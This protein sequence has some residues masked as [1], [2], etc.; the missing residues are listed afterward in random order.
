IL[1]TIQVPTLVINRTG[2]PV[3]NVEAA[4]DM[5]ARIPGARFVEFPGNMHTPDG[6]V[7]EVVGEIREFI[8]GVRGTAPVTR[9]L[10]TIVFVDIVAST[11]LATKLGD[12]PFRDLLDRWYAIL[13]RELADYG[14]REINRAGD[15][16]L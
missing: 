4:R 11:E 7:E 14:G 6:I 16:V 9:V 12:G 3:A 5:A 15:G 10:A 13:G 1:P 2:D 8:T